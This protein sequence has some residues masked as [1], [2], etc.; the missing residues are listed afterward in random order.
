[1]DKYLRYWT[2][3]LSKRH[4]KRT[5]KKKKHSERTQVENITI[6][7]EAKKTGLKESDGDAKLT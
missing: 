1:M 2:E 4:R 7:K 3:K 5:V 6:T